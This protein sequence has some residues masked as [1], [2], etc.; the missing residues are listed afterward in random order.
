MCNLQWC[1]LKIDHNA[2][3]E[4][5]LH[6]ETLSHAHDFLTEG[7]KL[8]ALQSFCHKIANHVISWTTLD[9]TVATPNL[10]G[11]HKMSC[12]Q[13]SCPLPRTCFP[14]LF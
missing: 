6:F 1:L 13:S 7:H 11:H 10:V 4:S 12:V 3:I 14:I 2:N 8:N 5:S 9:G